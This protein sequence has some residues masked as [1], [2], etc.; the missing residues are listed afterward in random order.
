M[1]KLSSVDKQRTSYL[2]VVYRLVKSPDFLTFLLIK[3]LLNSGADFKDFLLIFEISKNFNFQAVKEILD[4]T[5]L[6]IV[7]EDYK[8]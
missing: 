2:S 3:I 6:S 1:K 7:T 4:D 8:I 5:K